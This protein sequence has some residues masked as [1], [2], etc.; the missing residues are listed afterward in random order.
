[1]RL[2]HFIIL[3]FLGFTASGQGS[4][5]DYVNDLVMKYDDYVYRANIKTVQFHETSWEYAPPV[6]PLFGNQQLQLSF[7]DLDGDRKQY[8]VSFVH[9]NSDWTP[10]D[11]MVSEYLNGY[12]ELNFQNFSYSTNTIQKYTHYEL[13][14]PFLNSQNTVQFTKSGNYVA[15][16]Y[17]NG[18]R[19]SLVLCRRFM[20]FDERVNMSATF[21]Q[22]I[23]GGEQYNKQHIDFT[24]M[25]SGY[26][27]NNPYRDMK[28]VL[29][30]NNRWENAIS[31]IK[32][33]FLNGTQIIYSLDDASTFNA[34]NEFRYFD[35]RSTRFITERVKDIY[36]DKDLKFHATL[37]PDQ[38][39]ANK[40][41]LYYSDFNGNF[42]IKNRESTGDMDTEADYIEVEFFLPYNV[43]ESRGNFY[44]MGKLTDWR[45]TRNSKLTYNYERKGY[46]IKLNL[47]Q[48][49]Y[50]YIYVLSDDNRPGG[51]ETVTEGNYWD[52]ENDY[53]ILVY[54]RKFGTYYDQLIG[55]RKLNS[56]RR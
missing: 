16:V 4:D 54:H 50:N 23:G 29:M 18:D 25:P 26:D 49:F 38:V 11:L 52:T 8:A 37:L 44:I 3:F 22:P 15:Y 47:K 43:P 21:R 46:E 32:P 40:P 17:V 45:M 24:I 41:Y 7:D 31:G 14:F 9:C 10:S 1:M 28:V 27:I 35:L 20:V 19:N 5:D 55:Y 30:Q 33:T 39:R 51:D 42:L 48:G 6:I 36:R 34:G 2:L 12:Y 13:I 56:L 53:T